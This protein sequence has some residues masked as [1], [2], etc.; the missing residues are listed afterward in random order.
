MTI[1]W[2]GS[3]IDTRDC[4]RLAQRFTSDW[5]GDW[6][7]TEYML[8]SPWGHLLYYRVGNWNRRMNGECKGWW[9]AERNYGISL[10]GFELLNRPALVN[11]RLVKPQ[12]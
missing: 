1:T 5:R 12:E 10:D 7:Y 2:Q 6:L 3:R 11:M 4:E 8:L 9:W